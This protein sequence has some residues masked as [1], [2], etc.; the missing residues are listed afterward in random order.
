[1]SRTG[2]E[3]RRLNTSPKFVRS[4]QRTSALDLGATRLA[5]LHLGIRLGYLELGARGYA[6]K[7]LAKRLADGRLGVRVRRPLD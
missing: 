1:M 3:E 2:A 7:G 4:V 6:L 5:W